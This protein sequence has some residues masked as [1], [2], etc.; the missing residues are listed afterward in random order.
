MK[1]YFRGIKAGFRKWPASTWRDRVVFIAAL[2]ISASGLAIFWGLAAWCLLLVAH[3]M[4]AEAAEAAGV[5]KE[6]MI[7][8]L[9]VT[10]AICGAIIV[11]IGA[12]VASAAH[13]EKK[14]EK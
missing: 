10:V 3:L 2:L 13:I 4:I 7:R 5:S 12:T 9:A 6:E 11:A 1:A 8:T 14:G